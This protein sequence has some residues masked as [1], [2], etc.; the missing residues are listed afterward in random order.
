[1]K[2]VKMWFVNVAV[3]LFLFMTAGTALA[4]EKADVLREQTEKVLKTVATEAKNRE[5]A[6]KVNLFKQAGLSY[7]PSLVVPV[8]GVIECKGKEQL[9]MLM[10]MYNFDANY[11]LLFGRKEQFAKAYEL[12]NDIP[13]RLGLTGRFT[14]KTFTPDQIEKVL[15]NPDDPANRDLYVNYIDANLR[16]ML[17]AAKTDPEMLDLFF[18]FVYGAIIEGVYVACKLSLAAGTGENLLP[19]FNEQKTRLDKVWQ[20][21]GAY[22]A[23][24]ELDALVERPQRD[25]IFKPVI[26]ILTTKKGNL[27]EADVKEILSIVESDRDKLAFKCE[28]RTTD[29]PPARRKVDVLRIVLSLSFCCSTHGAYDSP[30]TM[31]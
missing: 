25:R 31:I 7:Q 4:Q 14:F 20:A 28:Y 6:E 11:A 1:M 27:A 30:K 26:E 22:A 16:D 17:E 10:G 19:L 8:E 15:D 29:T 2:L 24:P 12:R 18:D 5:S 9:G 21:L 13:N 23:D 3:A